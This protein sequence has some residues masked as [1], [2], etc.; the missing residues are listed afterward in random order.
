MFDTSI[1]AE[2]VIEEKIDCNDLVNSVQDGRNAFMDKDSGSLTHEAESELK[3]GEWGL[4]IGTVHKGYVDDSLRSGL[5]AQAVAVKLL[6]IEGLQGHR[7]WLDLYDFQLSELRGVA[8]NFSSN[9]L[10]GEWGLGIGTV[11]KGYVDDS[12]RSGLKAQAVAVKLLDIE[13]LQ[14]HR[15]WLRSVKKVVIESGGEDIHTPHT[16][17]TSVCTTSSHNKKAK[18]ENHREKEIAWNHLKFFDEEPSLRSLKIAVISRKW[19][20]STT[21]GG[22]E[23]HAHTL[24]TALA[25]RGHQVHVFTSPPLDNTKSQ[26]E[27]RTK[28]SH[29]SSPIIHWHEGEPGKWRYNKAWEQFQEENQREPF[30]V[31]HSE[32]V[33]LPFWLAR[34]LSNLVVSWHGIALESVQ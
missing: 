24:H 15:E 34:N 9:F 32:S 21:P 17:S 27:I 26:E 23:R 33:A 19:P 6:D 28:R 1:S 4:G 29:V 8:Q 3:D 25:R 30:D 13:G 16:P 12:L 14:G 7:E 2:L 22:M 18:S 20:I 11:H 31:I 10:L 5:K